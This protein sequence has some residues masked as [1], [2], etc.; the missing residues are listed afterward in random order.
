MVLV[1]AIA[2][3]V[4]C[5]L[6]VL[7]KSKPSA[8][9]LV[10]FACLSLEVLVVVLWLQNSSAISARNNHLYQ[11]LWA[12]FPWVAG[13]LQIGGLALL[14]IAFVGRLRSRTRSARSS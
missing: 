13:S 12:I 3:V 10:A 4:G 9:D 11:V 14:V 7:M 2:I 8:L 1:P 6:L 5:V